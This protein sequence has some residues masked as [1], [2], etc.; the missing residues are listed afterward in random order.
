[1][2]TKRLQ[3]E[4]SNQSHNMASG[5]VILT[6]LRSTLFFKLYVTSWCM[7]SGKVALKLFFYCSLTESKGTDCLG[8][9]ASKLQ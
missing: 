8:L 2:Q 6:L 1:M 4:H 7:C 5:D 3:Y 9:L